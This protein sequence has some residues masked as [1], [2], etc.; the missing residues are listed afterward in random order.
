M[1]Q[2]TINYESRENRF[3]KCE[4]VRSRLVYGNPN[5][6]PNPWLTVVIPTYRRVNLLKQALDS[7]LDQWHTDFFWDII[8]V[9]NEPDD[10]KENDTERL[11]RSI[12]SKRIMYYRNSENIWVGDNF[13]HCFQLARGKWVTMLHDDD[14][15][16][17]NTLQVL[18]HLIRAYDRKNAPL[19][20]I[21]AS[22][23]QVEYDPVRDEIKENIPEINEFWSNQ[24]IDYELY[25]LTHNNVKVLSHIGGAAPTNGSTFRRE[26]V[27]E[28]GGFNEDYGI[29]GDL[30]L[31]YNLENKYTAYQTMRP[32]GF[33]RWGMNSMMKKESIYLVIHDNFAFREYI[34]QKNWKNRL[35]GKLFRS[36][37]YRKFTTEAIQERIS[38]SNE[39]IAMSDFDDV[40]DKRP[41]PI[42]YLFYKCVI[43]RIYGYHKRRQGKR[44][45][46]IALREL[47]EQ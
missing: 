30:I 3:L 41:N 43:S 35:L 46:K 44:N 37:H 38:V 18:G 1:D 8:I 22:Y 24:P 26:A 40:Y 21:A 19:G 2:L 45:A 6:V 31:F 4:H 9:D 17:A 32:L 7:V 15:L 39:Q 36:C 10:G 12:D 11:I 47:E 14:L 20:A 23:I 28:V 42:W 25:Q 5:N 27:I 16:M 33:Y 34:Y 13:N 29:S